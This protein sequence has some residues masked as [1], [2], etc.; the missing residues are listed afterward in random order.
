MENNEKE[1]LENFGKELIERCF[2]VPFTNFEFYKNNDKKVKEDRFYNMK[3]Y[4]EL[5]PNDL[6]VYSIVHQS[7]MTSVLSGL[8]NFLDNN[9]EYRVMYMDSDANSKP[10]DVMSLSVGHGEIFGKDG[11]IMK[12]SKHRNLLKEDLYDYDP[13][14]E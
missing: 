10:V 8:L 7:I 11:W 1:I 13:K 2:D 3:Y 6:E 4:K 12:F 5:M 14:P 9:L